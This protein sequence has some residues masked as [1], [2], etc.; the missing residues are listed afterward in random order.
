[1]VIADGAEELL[2]DVVGP[3]Q[4]RAVVAVEESWP[5]AGA[6]LEEVR[7]GRLEGPDACLIVPDLGEQILQPLSDRAARRLV[8]VLQEACGLM[9]PAVGDPDRRPQGIGGS[10]PFGDQRPQLSQFGR[11]APFS[12]SRPREASIAAR[13]S[14]SLS[15]EA[16]SGGRSSSVSALRTARQ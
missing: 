10:E 13:R 15:P 6:D 5:V 8:L 9:N 7:H 16:H 4:A 14:W 3:G 1:M 2:Q 12:A 11:E